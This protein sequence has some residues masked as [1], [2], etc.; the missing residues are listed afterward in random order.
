MSTAQL[1]GRATGLGTT[2]RTDRWWATPLL[3]GLAFAVILGYATWA[4]FQNQYYYQAPYLSPLYSPVLF[5]DPTQPARRRSD[6]AWFGVKPAWWPAFLPFSPAFLILVFPGSFRLTCYYYRKAYYR[7]YFC[8]RPPARWA[9]RCPAD[10]NGETGPAHL[11]EPAPLHAVLRAR[12]HRRSSTTTRSWRS[13]GRPVRHRRR[14]AWCCSINAI[15]ARRLHV[16][17]PL[18]PPP[19]RRPDRLLLVRRARRAPRYGVWK[20]S[21]WFNARHMLFAWISLFWV[22]FD[23]PLRA[24]GL[25]GRHPDLNTWGS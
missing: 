10:Y 13:S 22:G 23:R 14:H 11:P 15:A 24:P 19:D 7:S 6:H 18:L 25:D 8:G 9:P 12:L 4:A 20:K 16:R 17:L 3:Q 2:A 1:D 21:T 5:T